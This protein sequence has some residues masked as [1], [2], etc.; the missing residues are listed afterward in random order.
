MENVSAAAASKKKAKKGVKKRGQVQLNRR[1]DLYF[2][3]LSGL[4][5]PDPF[6][7][8]LPFFDFD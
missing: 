5:E 6:F 8:F 4:I 7:A 1:L 3:R 2:L